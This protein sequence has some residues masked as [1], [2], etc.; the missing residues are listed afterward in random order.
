VTVGTTAAGEVTIDGPA[1]EDP[2]QVKVLGTLQVTGLAERFEQAK[3]AELVT[4]FALHRHGTEPDTLMEAMWPEQP[5]SLQRLRTVVARARSALGKETDT[6]H[7]LPIIA[8]GELYQV[9][10]KV[11]CDLDRFTHHV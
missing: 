2:P 1:Q 11:S 7:Y 5:A 10:P 8:K 9:S 3:C 6:E 4:Y